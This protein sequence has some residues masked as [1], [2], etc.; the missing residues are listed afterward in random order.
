M[1][2]ILAGIGNEHMDEI[3]IL[4]ISSA[5][6]ISIIFFRKQLRVIPHYKL[7]VCAF[8]SL[9]I[10]NLSTLVEHYIWLDFFNF[11]EHSAYTISA[12]LLFLWCY[13][14]FKKEK[15]TSKS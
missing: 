8:I 7:S 12:I 1:G 6:C 13:K 9:L 15:D 4:F 5:I 10:G 2:G 3:S 14:Y 11:V